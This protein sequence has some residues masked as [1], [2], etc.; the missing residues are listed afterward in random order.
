MTWVPRCDISRNVMRCSCVIAASACPEA[1]STTRTVCASNRYASRLTAGVA[2]LAG[3]RHRE[4]TYLLGNSVRPDQRG[5]EEPYWVG[6]KGWGW[7][8]RVWG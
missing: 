5:S 4:R 7:V 2:S 1:R 8:R 6:E 3:T